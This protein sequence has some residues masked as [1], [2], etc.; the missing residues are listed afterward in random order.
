MSGPLRSGASVIPAGFT[1]LQSWLNFGYF[2]IG[3]I[4]KVNKIYI[5]ID[6][7]YFIYFLFYWTVFSSSHLAAGGGGWRRCCEPILPE[8]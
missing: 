1:A 2:C 4:M 5:Y 8:L 6:V 3:N 7:F